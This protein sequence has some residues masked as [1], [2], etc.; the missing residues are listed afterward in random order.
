MP[1]IGKAKKKLKGPVHA[2]SFGLEKY[3]ENCIYHT[4]MHRTEAGADLAMTYHRRME[5][6]STAAA[7]DPPTQS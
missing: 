3:S 5:L 4:Y 1:T 7:P 2:R 6:D